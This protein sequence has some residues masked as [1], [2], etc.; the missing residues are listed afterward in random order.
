MIGFLF[1]TGS[2]FFLLLCMP[3]IFNLKKKTFFF[4]DAD[5]VNF[6]LVGAGYICIV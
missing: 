6:T 3:G 1:I 4:L 5:V 2:G